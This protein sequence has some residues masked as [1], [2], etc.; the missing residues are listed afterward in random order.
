MWC[1]YEVPRMTLLHNL[2]RAMQLD[3]SKDMYVHVLICTS[4]NFNTLMPE[5]WK[6]WC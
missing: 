1:G 4:Y 2:K 5:V 3:H 6:L